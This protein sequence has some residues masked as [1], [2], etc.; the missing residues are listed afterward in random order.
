[1]KVNCQQ[2]HSMQKVPTHR[3]VGITLVTYVAQN[4][5]AQKRCNPEPRAHRR[6]S[7]TGV[8]VAKWRQQENDNSGWH[9]LQEVPDAERGDELKRRL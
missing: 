3:K 5:A 1:M 7:V 2:M 8:D 9:S 4:G 6:G